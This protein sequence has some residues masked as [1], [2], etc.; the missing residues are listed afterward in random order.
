MRGGDELVLMQPGLRM[1]SDRL[2][3]SAEPAGPTQLAPPP[4]LYDGAPYSAWS[5]SLHR[6]MPLPSGA[7]ILFESTVEE[8]TGL[9][10]EVV[11]DAFAQGPTDR[12]ASIFGCGNPFLVGAL[13]VRYG[14]PAD[15]VLTTTGVANGLR[16]VL[17]ALVRP[18]DKVLVETPGFDVLTGLAQAAGL[19]VV[20][21]AR[22]AP[23]FDLDADRLAEALTPGV[24]MVVISN[25]HNPSGRWLSEDALLRLAEVAARRD[26]WLVVDEVYADF[27]RRGGDHL[28]SAPNLIRLNSL[29]K[30]FG[31]YGLRCGWIIADPT[32]AQRIAVA[33]EAR[34]FGASKLTHAIAAVILERPGRFETHWRRILVER[35]PILA[36]H[37]MAMRDEGLIDGSMPEF[38]CMAFPRLPGHPDTLELARRLWRDHQLVTAPGEMFGLPGY[39]RLGLGQP[40][41]QLDEGLSRLHRALRS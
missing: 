10:A 38:G 1:P 25:L 14:V 19:Q 8:P 5:R 20:P 7:R 21:L 24:R 27:A 17:A 32:V 11:A 16:Q 36:R 41:E 13:A 35:R 9:L 22:P 12:Y 15:A 34:E 2:S 39:M 3:A 33:N 4:S 23:D 6:R 28:P 31:L 37:L 29:T 18:Q 26:A 40:P 30:V